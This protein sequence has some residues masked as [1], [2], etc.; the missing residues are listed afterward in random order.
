MHRSLV[1]LVLTM[2]V[3]L[4]GHPETVADC[5]DPDC[6]TVVDGMNTFL[7]R[8]MEWFDDVRP[9]E[10]P[11]LVQSYGW[12]TSL[13]FPPDE[14]DP[15]SCVNSPCAP[16]PLAELQWRGDIYDQSLTAIWFTERAR[17]DFIRGEDPGANLHRARRLLDAGIFLEDHDPYADGR[18]RTAYW[19]NDLLNPDRTQSSIM[20]PDAAT[21]NISWFGIAL[22]RFYQVTELTNYLDP[23]TRDGYLDV[24]VEKGNWIL[25]NCTDQHPCG[26]TG[27]YSG[28]DQIPFAW[29]STEHNIDA[30]VFAKN[31]YH[32]TGDPK[33]KDMAERAQCFVQSMFV[34]VDSCGY[35]QTGT[36][37]DGITPNPSPIPADAQAWTTLAR[38]DDEAIDTDERAACAMQ[39]LLDNLK[40]GCESYVLPCDGVKFSDVGKN[41]QCEVTASAALALVGRDKD[42]PEAESFL[43]L[44]DWVRVNAAPSY[45]GI[46][47]GI[48]I[49]ATPCPE[50]AWTGYGEYAWYYPLLH[51]ASS[52]WT[53]LACTYHQE[54]NEWA[55]PL[56]TIPEPST[57][58]LLAAGAAS[59]L[60]VN[61]WRR[62]IRAN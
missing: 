37:D 26:F 48:G 15:P 25:D 60:L 2:T 54:G 58:L 36:L 9:L 28:W 14:L 34:P 61:A 13:S 35:Y 4:A 10:Q 62:G 12:D 47:D 40:D 6:A 17:R 31:L 20:D 59:A 8:Q 18:L 29:K 22:T 44:L 24:A 23:S 5:P 52:N 33:W 7:V 56:R 41:M 43:G 30:W 38:N 21:G 16:A 51:V 27:G 32:L 19:A 39:W 57:L 45:D 1:T 3:A 50:A 46:E 53:G 49:V 11:P 42:D 55:N